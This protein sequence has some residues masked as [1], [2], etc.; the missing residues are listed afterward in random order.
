MNVFN[1]VGGPVVAIVN[2]ASGGTTYADATV[3]PRLAYRTIATVD[4]SL[5]GGVSLPTDPQLGD[6]VEVYFGSSPP[7]NIY[8]TV[9]MAFIALA[10]GG[11]NLNSWNGSPPGSNGHARATYLGLDPAGSGLNVWGITPGA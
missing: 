3:I 7:S 6:I 10:A 4:S 1:S 9:G 5:G 2:V 8:P 11:P